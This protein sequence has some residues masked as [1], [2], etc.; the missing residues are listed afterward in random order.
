MAGLLYRR[1]PPRWGGQFPSLLLFCFYPHGYISSDRIVSPV[2]YRLTR[3]FPRSY[4]ACPGCFPGRIP[5]APVVS[6]SYTACPGCF[7]GHIVRLIRLSPRGFYRPVGLSPVIIPLCSHHQ[8]HRRLRRYR[9]L[10]LCRRHYLQSRSYPDL[11][12]RNRSCQDL[13]LR[14]RLHLLLHLPAHTSW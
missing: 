14:R 4:T 2:I 1:H 12:L 5:L 7:P 3:L 11:R 6:R 13:R 9:R 10:R 8:Q